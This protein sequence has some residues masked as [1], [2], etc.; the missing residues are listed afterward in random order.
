MGAIHQQAVQ[1]GVAV[2][3]GVGADPKGGLVGRSAELDQLRLAVRQVTDGTG[4]AMLVTGEAGIGKTRVVTEG[5]DTARRLG[6]QV[7]RGAA[8]EL[9]WRRPFGAIADC[10]GIGGSP[11]DRRRAAITRL[12]EENVGGVDASWFGAS[13]Q[14]EFRV[15]EA[16]VALVEELST[17]SP[18]MAAVEDLQWADPSTLLVLQRLGRRVGQLPVLLVGTARPVPRSQQLEGCLHGLRASGATELPLGPLDEAAGTRLVEQ[19]VGA[20]PGPGLVA[21]VAGARGNPLFITELVGALQRDGSIQLGP[22]GTAELTSVGIPPSLPLLIL[23]RLSFLAPAT[24][25]LLRVASVLGSSFAVADLSGVVGR[26]TAALLAA[27]EQAMAAG[28]LE[29]RGELLGFR[30]DLIWEALYQDLPAPMRRSLHL[31]AGRALAAAGAPA[32]QVAEQLVRGA[33]PGDTQAV[34]W[35]QRAAHEAASRAP[36]VAVEL[37]QR[38]LE[39][40]DPPT[41]A[42][43]G[44]WP[45]RRSA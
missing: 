16:L 28:I 32:E 29:S 34:A 7:L 39:F 6:V 43:M 36:A 25:E 40:A 24:L 19:L 38:A 30:H 37:L 41:R 4:Q 3:R 27:L 10:L 17:R 23:H 11:P 31:D 33:S 8:E 42:G 5:L 20:P 18:V 35:L 15:V 9:E 22:D 2:A 14:A 21:Q 1:G 44:C 12:L 45:S 26:P 13:P